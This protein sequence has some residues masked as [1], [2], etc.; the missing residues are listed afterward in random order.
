MKR[1]VVF[2][3]LLTAFLHG[4][5][6]QQSL[7]QQY[8]EKYKDMAIEQM[9]RYGIPASIT[10]A[11]G[12]L[13]S[14]AGTSMLATKAHNHFGIKTGGNW[15]GPY[16]VKDDDKQGEHFRKYD[17][18]RQSYEDHSLFLSTRGRY[19]SLFKLSQTDYKAWAH[20]L[21][22]AGYA[23][24]P[25]YAQ[26]LI[27][28]IEIYNLAR[29]DRS[30]APS[31]KTPAASTA[32][33]SAPS[34]GENRGKKDLV[35]GRANGR[36]YVVA[37]PGDT[38]ATIAREMEADEQ[39]LRKYNEVSPAHSLAA[40]DVVYLQKK[41]SHVAGGLRGKYHVVAAGES[42]YTISQQYGVRLMTLIKANP[43]AATRAPKVGDTLLLQ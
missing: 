18:A 38:F 29:Y 7:Y 17:N 4:A 19:S 37:R 9:R 32:P 43:A 35:V 31:Y 20:G 13:E 8:I 42:L 33:R 14:G 28:L 12:L 10:L 25:E 6:A 1:F 39:K 11:Q 3:L 41:R 5:V 2:L 36:Y 24:N 27:S 15:T 16:V 21:K 23:T 22:A 26:K 30:A 34:G 40:G